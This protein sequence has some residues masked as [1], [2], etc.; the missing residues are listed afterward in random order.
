MFGAF[1]APGVWKVAIRI[2]R[3]AELL[4]P[5]GEKAHAGSDILAF[6][7]LVIPADEKEH[8]LVFLL[9]GRNVVKGY[10]EVSVGTLSSAIVHPRDVFRP[11]IVFGAAGV[12]VA[13]NHPSGDSSP[14]AED[15]AVTARLRDVGTLVG[16]PLIDHVIVGEDRYFSFLERGYMKSS[17]AGGGDSHET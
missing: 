12:I 1:D 6:S 16:I 10:A 13:H 17:G 5:L 15:L 9:D 2:S 4:P 8:F 7:H 14:S 11:A 3:V